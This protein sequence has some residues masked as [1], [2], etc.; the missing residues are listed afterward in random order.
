[1]NF[2][3]LVLGFYLWHLFGVA[4][5]LHRLLSHHSFRCPKLVEYQFVMAAYLA[6]HGSP[7]WWATMHRAHHRHVDTPLDPHAPGN[8]VL[9]AYTF[10]KG[11]KYAD[12]I[13][14]IKQSPDL[15]KDPLYRFLECGGNWPVGYALNVV[16]CIAFRVALFYIF[17]WQVALASLIGGI[18]AL[19]VPLILNIVCHI[20]QL[21]KRNFETGDDS[22][23]VWWMSIVCLGEGWHNNH[24]AHPNSARAGLNDKEFDISWTVIKTLRRFSLVSHANEFPSTHR[25]HLPVE[26]ELVVSSRK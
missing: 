14:P 6:F 7:I 9:G 16:I 21:G 2:V 13:D 17:G 19:N 26:P 10:Y 12:H 8:G 11:F 25:H 4:I 3:L 20:P 18:M 1:M 15:V 24:H 22:V 23:N 5:G